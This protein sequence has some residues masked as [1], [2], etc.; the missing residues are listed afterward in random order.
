MTRGN[1]RQKER[2]DIKD[3][4]RNKKK[5]R[6][7]GGETR[8]REEKSRGFPV[9]SV[10]IPEVYEGFEVKWK[11][12]DK[13][14]VCSA[15]GR[16]TKHHTAS[17]PRPFYLR[18]GGFPFFIR[19]WAS[20]GLFFL[21]LLHIL[22]PGLRS[23]PSDSNNN[24]HVISFHQ[25]RNSRWEIGGI[26]KL[27]TEQTNKDNQPKTEMIQLESENRT[28]AFRLHESEERR[29]LGREVDCILK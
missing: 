27:K 4:R 8:R 18:E 17:F 23:P 16:T 25:R 10:R 1:E 9:N 20:V 6:Q 26:L 12:L 21:I 11:W 24:T 22:S 28:D 3:K 14:D 5:K 13:G 15:A 29:S 19:I 7:K 2:N